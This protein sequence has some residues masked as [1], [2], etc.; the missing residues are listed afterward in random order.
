MQSALR[1]VG[2]KGETERELVHLKKKGDTQ[3]A[4]E[5]KSKE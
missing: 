2:G 1:E 4:D 5:N 3:G